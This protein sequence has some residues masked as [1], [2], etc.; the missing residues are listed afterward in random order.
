MSARSITCVAPHRCRSASAR[1]VCGALAGTVL[2]ASCTWDWD[3][4]EQGT[5]EMPGEVRVDLSAE[6]MCLAP[7]SPLVLTWSSE[8]ATECTAEGPSW[9]GPREADGTEA[10]S[11]PAPGSYTIRCTGPDGEASDSVQVLVDPGGAA[12][13]DAITAPFG[14][15][16]LGDGTTEEWQAERHLAEELQDGEYPGSRD[17]VATFRVSWDETRLYVTVSVVDDDLQYVEGM[18]ELD[19]DVVE[20]MANGRNDEPYR[21]PAGA[22]R[23]DVDDHRLVF[24]PEGQR[25]T[26][27]PAQPRGDDV[28]QQAYSTTQGYEV[29]VGIRWPFVLG[30]DGHV[31][32]PGDQVGFNV[33][34]VDRDL[35]EAA[36][37][38]VIWRLSEFRWRN[39]TGWGTVVLRCPPA[40]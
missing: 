4:L 23:F 28:V 16:D 21:T 20:V 25:W 14:A 38:T 24:S 18:V 31:P 5:G 11:E 40:S 32:S 1:R 13:A 37:S 39:T 15:R 17:L 34:A 22:F 10:L 33:A 3:R 12:P 27:D 6:T 30:S 26:T 7:G 29:E 19:H 8:G 35:D 2:L 36:S 9:D